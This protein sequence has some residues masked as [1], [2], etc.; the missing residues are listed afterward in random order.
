MWHKKKKKLIF[1]QTNIDFIKKLNHKKKAKHKNK[2]NKKKLNLFTQK[3]PIQ[4]YKM[5]ETY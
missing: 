3:F 1:I 4:T 2:K 5:I